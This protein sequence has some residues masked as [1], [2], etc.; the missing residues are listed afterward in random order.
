[1]A[2]SRN[3]TS[4]HIHTLSV[5]IAVIG[6]AVTA[7]SANQHSWK[8]AVLAGV[9]A[10]LLS[11]GTVSF[12]WNLLA[13]RWTRKEREEDMRILYQLLEDKIQATQESF[14]RTHYELAE[15]SESFGLTNIL[16][17]RMKSAEVRAGLSTSS[18]FLMVCIVDSDWRDRY[19]GDLVAMIQSGGSVEIFI[20]D[21]TDEQLMN[22]ISVRFQRPVS[23][24]ILA[25]YESIE[26]VKREAMSEP[27]CGALS[28][29]FLRTM[30]SYTCYRFEGADGDNRTNFGMIR[31][32][33]NV[34]RRGNSLP[35]LKFIKSGLIWEFVSNDMKSIANDPHFISKVSRNDMSLT[36][37][38]RDATSPGEGQ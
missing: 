28:L 30:P 19:F 9:G 7:M 31:L 36:A 23:Q 6:L 34:I 26:E 24:D 22:E 11:A 1:M 13:E 15:G 14:L 27:G 32:Y 25:L 2:R 12:L 29:H 10:A 37:A 4:E 3:L 33:G 38:P 18:R 16:L 35:A 20:P 21:P 5:L 8:Q 17:H